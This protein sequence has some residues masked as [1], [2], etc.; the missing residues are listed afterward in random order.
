MMTW[1]AWDGAD[2]GNAEA[3]KATPA[4][5]REGRAPAAGR[6][7]RLWRRRRAGRAGLRLALERLARGRGPAR[8]AL[9]PARGDFRAPARGRHP[10]RGRCS[11]RLMADR[12]TRTARRASAVA[13][14]GAA[15]GEV[16]SA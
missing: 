6:A 13:E 16:T 4:P 15:S 9:V 8:R 7:R 10:G 5:G 2:A 14:P 1:W 3:R 11:G 12:S